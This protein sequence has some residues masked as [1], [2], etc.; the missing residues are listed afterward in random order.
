M[1]AERLK[2]LRKQYGYTQEQLASLI[3]VE[4]SSIGKYEGKSHI[5]PSDDIKYKIAELFN[6]SVDYLLGYSDS[7]TPLNIDSSFSD[8]EL[9][10]VNDFRSL[11][12]Q[13]KEYILQTM[14]MAVNI[15]KNDI[16]P[17]VEKQ[18]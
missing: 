12:K 18:A 5:I 11:N 13:G 8:V 17:D 7:P 1:F 4:R 10:L 14:A 9:Q 2:A 6:V 3:G 16:V 15:Y